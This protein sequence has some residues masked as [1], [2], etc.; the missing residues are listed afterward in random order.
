MATMTSILESNDVNVS[1]IE[2][3]SERFKEMRALVRKVDRAERKLE[4]TLRDAQH[5]MNKK[6]YQR[7]KLLSVGINIVEER[8]SFVD[9]KST[10]KELYLLETD[11]KLREKCQNTASKQFFE[12]K[13][14]ETLPAWIHR[15][16]GVIEIVKSGGH[17]NELQWRSKAAAMLLNCIE[18][19]KLADDSEN[20][21][22]RLRKLHLEINAIVSNEVIRIL[23]DIKKDYILSL[24][25]E[26]PLS[27]SNKRLN[28]VKATI[29]AEHAAVP[30]PTKTWSE[31][32]IQNRIRQYKA[33]PPPPT[34][35]CVTSMKMTGS[36]SLDGQLHPVDPNRPRISAKDYHNISGLVEFKQLAADGNFKQAVK[37]FHKVFR[38]PKGCASE[39][40]RHSVTLDTFKTLMCAFKN[41][42][43]ID[44]DQA[45]KVIDMIKRW[46]LEP[47]ITVFNIMIQACEYQSRWRRALEIINTMK[48]THNLNPN[49][50][51]MKILLN[52]CRYAMDEPGIIYETL[53]MQEFP[54]K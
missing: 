5:E 13:I 26:T 25:N 29:E 3:P 23:N 47:D 51:T 14:E 19:A 48:K 30:N 20:S 7:K 17:A 21:V 41:S 40:T 15:L 50:A 43:E 44:F 38:P 52:C 36:F 49:H 54:R 4:R 6:L 33:K 24:D 8:N 46:D 12:N 39:L 10:G 22:I 1:Y 18:F 34:L 11:E 37:V 28:E 53:R 27:E 45:Y 2:E 42:K 31:G 35:E 9:N 32:L 16:T